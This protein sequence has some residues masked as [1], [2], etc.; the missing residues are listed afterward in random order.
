MFWAIAF[1]LEAVILALLAWNV[2]RADNDNNKGLA[3][4]LF[5]AVAVV[6]GAGDI[7]LAALAM[8]MHWVW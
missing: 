8:F 1:S 3:A 6:F 5:W 2:H 7:I 4:G